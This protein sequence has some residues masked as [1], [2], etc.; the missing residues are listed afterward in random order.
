MNNVFNL[1]YT[2]YEYVLYTAHY[3]WL[4]EKHRKVF[5]KIC[6]HS[7]CS[8]YIRRQ[9]F[10][11]KCTIVFLH[12]FF[13]QP[14]SIYTCLYIYLHVYIIKFTKVNIT[15]MASRLKLHTDTCLTPGTGVQTM[16]HFRRVSNIQHE[17]NLQRRGA[18]GVIEINF[19][20]FLFWP[21]I[22]LMTDQTSYFSSY[23]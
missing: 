6:I 3:F 12:G 23:W 1:F 5:F 19:C 4:S 9:Y 15:S 13:L 16:S 10:K 17:S 7:F 20:S 8:I 18:H 2:F 22:A 11:P 14:N 21:L